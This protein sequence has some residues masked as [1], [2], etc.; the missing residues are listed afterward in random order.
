MLFDAVIGNSS[1]GIIEAPMWYTSINIGDE[2]RVDYDLV[3]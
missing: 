1:S 2:Q 3:M